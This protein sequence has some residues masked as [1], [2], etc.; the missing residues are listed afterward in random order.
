MATMRELRRRINSVHSSQKITGAMKM[1]SSA[2]MR[3]VEISLEHARPYEEQL[4]RIMNHIDGQD[5]DYISLLTEERELKQVTLVALASDEGLC[6]A[7]NMNIL[8]SLTETV[9]DY[10]QKMDTPV[11]VYPVGRKIISGIRRMKGIKQ[12]GIPEEFEQ[13]KYAEA[14]RILTD[15][16]VARFIKGETDRV[17]LIYTHYISRGTQRVA[18]LQL[19]PFLPINKR[20]T[21]E[22]AGPD[23]PEKKLYYLY[24]PD[25]QSIFEIL[26]PL[27]VRTMFYKTLLESQTS[28]QAMRILAMQ[29][30]NDNAVKLLGK[31]QLEYNKLRQQ[32]I[33]SELLDIA[34]ANFSES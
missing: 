12:H 32:S 28:E 19:L 16:L 9:K 15:E 33:T 30:A 7:F 5:C 22:Q 21:P 2:R 26:Y 11:E 1:I 3:K 29:S 20:Q 27:V 23:R 18:H 6:G 10:Q 24:E 13:K 25:C 8:K 14:I 31:L 34:G 4:Q 17:E